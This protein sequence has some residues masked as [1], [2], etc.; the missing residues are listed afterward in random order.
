MGTRTGRGVGG[1][2]GAAGGLSASE[3]ELISAQSDLAATKMEARDM[4]KRLDKYTQDWAFG[5]GKPGSRDAYEKEWEAKLDSI[6][7]KTAAVKK[8]TK[9]VGD[10]GK[11]RIM[12]D[13]VQYGMRTRDVRRTALALEKVWPKLP[14]GP[15]RT[16]AKDAAGFLV[17]RAAVGWKTPADSKRYLASVAPTVGEIARFLKM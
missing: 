7:A 8:L 4:E 6:P 14:D 2:G 1:G 13:D 9:S 11:T 16:K 15:L 12:F 17:G 10:L 5:D 3:R